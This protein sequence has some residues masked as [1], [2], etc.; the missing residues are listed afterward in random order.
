M[1]LPY[2]K[3]T[4]IILRRKSNTFFVIRI[5]DTNLMLGICQTR[6]IPL[7]DKIKNLLRDKMNAFLPEKFGTDIVY[8]LGWAIEF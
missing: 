8:P 7:K 1:R 4:L 3:L 2:Y 5:A 6:K